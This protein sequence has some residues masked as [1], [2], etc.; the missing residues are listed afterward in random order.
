MDDFGDGIPKDS[1]FS[2]PQAVSLVKSR[3]RN[4]RCRK[5][6]NEISY[7]IQRLTLQVQATTQNIFVLSSCNVTVH[8]LPNVDHLSWVI[9]IIHSPR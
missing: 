1:P 6:N 5:R 4:V 2:H 8:V 9:L 7:E 3:K